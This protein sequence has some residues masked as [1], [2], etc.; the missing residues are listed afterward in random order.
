MK[1][2]LALVALGLTLAIAHPGPAAPLAPLVLGWEQYFK[3]DWKADTLKGQPVVW[4]H[5]LNDWGMPAR[6]IQLLVEGL[7]Q[8]GQVT[9]QRV[10]WL[11]TDLTPGTRAYFEVRT[12][13]AASAYRVQVFAFEW[14]Q[15]AGDRM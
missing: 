11:G 15:G 5:I 14:I 6:S 8:S 9:S 7:D 4:G 12:P 1:R 10:A 3:L 13:S 2:I